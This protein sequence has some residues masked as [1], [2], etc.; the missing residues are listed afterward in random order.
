MVSKFQYLA[1]P[2]ERHKSSDR[3]PNVTSQPSDINAAFQQISRV[4][5]AD[6]RGRV[7]GVCAGADKLGCSFVAR[8]LAICAAQSRFDTCLI[9]M[10]ITQNAHMTAFASPQL[11]GYYGGVSGPYDCGFGTSPF[12]R[13]SPSVVNQH[14]FREN[15]AAYM[16]LYTVGTIQLSFSG[17]LWNKLKDG[18][19][20]HIAPARDYWHAIRDRYAMVFV[21]V[22]AISRSDSGN[23]VF[24]EMDGVIMVT[25]HATAHANAGLLNA[26]ANTGGKC[27]G[28]IINGYAQSS[29]VGGSA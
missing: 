26:V 27:I 14:G 18:Q 29:R 25:D 15:D 13:V 24:G 1:T 21:D 6:G 9:D 3:E 16:G 19:S 23:T 20:V 17:F 22:P 2:P 11:Q 8:Q 28:A 12:W 4:S 5:R 7:F 10:D